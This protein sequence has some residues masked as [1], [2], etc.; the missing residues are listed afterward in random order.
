[1]ALGMI[2]G[3]LFGGGSEKQ[4]QQSS[5]PHKYASQGFALR[6]RDS[7]L[8][9]GKDP[10]FY[11]GQRLAP[12]PASQA[13]KVVA[14]LTNFAKNKKPNAV[15]LVKQSQQ[16]GVPVTEVTETQS[17]LPTDQTKYTKINYSAANTPIDIDLDQ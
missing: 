17:D 11:K 8:A 7:L 2:I 3:S 9:A 16:K 4:Q 5:I 6:A 13:Q 1:M 14:N 12:I 10:I 15:G